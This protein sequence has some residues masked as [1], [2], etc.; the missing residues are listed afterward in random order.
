MVTIEN[1]KNSKYLVIACNWLPQSRLIV[2][3]DSLESITAVEKA[4]E[5]YNLH[6]HTANYNFT[7]QLHVFIDDLYISVKGIKY[8]FR[9]KHS[10]NNMLAFLE[11]GD[12]ITYLIDNDEVIVKIYDYD[13]DYNR[14]RCQVGEE[15]KKYNMTTILKRYSTGTIKGFTSNNER[16]IA[17]SII[18]CSKLTQEG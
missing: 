9:V 8:L 16:Y 10:G 14:F 15:E 7:F 5:S 11:A 4:K 13:K 18:L 17:P 3:V 1:I 12:K 2:I 6:C